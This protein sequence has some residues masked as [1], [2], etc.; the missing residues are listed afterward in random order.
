MYSVFVA[1]SIN[2]QFLSHELYNHSTLH[3]C[4][5]SVNSIIII[6]QQ[7]LQ[8]VTAGK[9]SGKNITTLAT[10]TQGELYSYCGQLQMSDNENE[11]LC[12]SRLNS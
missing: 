1:I 2:Q 12:Y 11:A 9:N 8:V 5:I 3:L 6:D 10:L 4:L 7:A